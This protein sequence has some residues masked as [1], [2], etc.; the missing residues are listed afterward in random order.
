VE[1]SSKVFANKLCFFIFYLAIGIF[2]ISNFGLVNNS[3][4]WDVHWNKVNDLNYSPTYP[5]A[6]HFLFNV[7]NS[8]QSSFLWN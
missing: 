3:V 8:S 6:Y 4:D 2:N 1:G 7:F 5:S